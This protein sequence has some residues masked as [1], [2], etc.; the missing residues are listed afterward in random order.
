MTITRSG[1]TLLFRP[2]ALLAATILIVIIVL[3]VSMVLF[4]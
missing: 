2:L 4:F 1:I 3:K